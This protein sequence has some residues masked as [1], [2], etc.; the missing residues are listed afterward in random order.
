MPYDGEY[1]G[2]GPLRRIA[3]TPRVQELLRRSKVMPAGPVD[4]AA[5][6]VPLPAPPPSRRPPALV[7]AIDGS[8]AE[9]DVR[10]GYPGAKVGYVTVASVLLDLKLM[11]ALDERRPADPKAFRETERAATVDASLPGTNVVT[12]HQHCARDSFRDEVYD[13]FRGLVVDEEDG[14]PLIDTYEH[15][16]SLKPTSADVACPYVE[17]GCE[18]KF[19]IAPATKC[20]GCERARPIHSTDALRIQERFREFGTNGEAFGLVMQIAER[21][22]LVHLLRCFERRGLLGK[23]DRL[24]FF[25]DG[26]L[27]VFGPP[28]WLSKAIDAELKRLNAAARAAAGCDLLIL[29]I[30]KEGQFA[31]HFEEADRTETPGETLFQPGQYLL[32]TDD[33]I[34][35]R[36]V[37]S[38]SDKP[39]GVDTYFGRKFFYKTRRGERIVASLPL[40]GEAREELRSADPSRYPRLGDACALLDELGSSRFANAVVPIVSAHAHAAIPLH[41]GQKVLQQLTRALMREGR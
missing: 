11:N 17:S 23:I 29:G 26:P 22:L 6:A 19:P 4:P 34:K 37:L 36:I 18:A 39:Y 15:L 9:V 16:L 20:C 31:G 2:Y 27:A 1:A 28:A 7:L 30:E 35:R 25:V 40:A 21:L 33:Y 14:A 3:E 32:L 41:L 38:D 5:V 12:R 13:L 24:A 8:Y 10:N